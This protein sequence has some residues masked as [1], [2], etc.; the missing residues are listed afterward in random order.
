M[1]GHGVIYLFSLL[2]KGIRTDQIN[3]QCMPRDQ[4][5]IL[6]WQFAVLLGFVLFKAATY[7]ACPQ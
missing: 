1:K 5:W 4:F 6:D 7:V 3:A 2:T